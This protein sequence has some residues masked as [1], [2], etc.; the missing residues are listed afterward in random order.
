LAAK[1]GYAIIIT[2]AV[3]FAV[4]KPGGRAGQET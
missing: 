2:F 4:S 3:I 1:F